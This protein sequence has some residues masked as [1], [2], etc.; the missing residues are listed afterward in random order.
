VASDQ[1]ILSI[2][3]SVPFGLSPT[4]LAIIVGVILLA[5]FGWWQY[6]AEN[7]GHTPLVS[8]HLFQNRQFTSGAVVMA[9]LTFG[10]VGLI[11]AV[12][13]FLQSTRNLDALHTGY[14]LLPMSLMM[15]VVAP[16]SAAISKHI[17]AKHLIQAGL[18][19]AALA[20]LVLHFSIH[21]T[22]GPWD[23]TPG[24]MLFG[25][26]MGLVMAQVSNVTL[27]AVSPEQAG[28]ASGVN[29]TLRQVGSSFGSAIIGAVLLTTLTGSLYSGIK[30]SSVIPES[31]K[32]SLATSISSQASSVEL[33]GVSQGRKDNAFTP[34]IQAELTRIAHQAS[35]DGARRA[36]LYMGAFIGLGFVASFYAAQ[37]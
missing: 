2:C 23:F 35:A 25:A 1:A 4:P 11:F 27:S 26:G 3:H 29:N 8:V 37:C 5:V 34:Q 12:P 6:N 28:E 13:V 16:T 14:A 17:A 18:I 36:V 19:L 15:L 9:L 32:Q 10:M 22:S 31:A 20:S 21:A 33:G 7:H 24:L 30:S